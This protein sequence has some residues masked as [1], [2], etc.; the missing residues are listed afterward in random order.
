MKQGL[1]FK[2]HGRHTGNAIPVA[3]PLKQGLIFKVRGVISPH[4]QSVARCIS[5]FCQSE[6]VGVE[7]VVFIRVFYRLFWVGPL[8]ESGGILRYR[9]GFL[10]AG[11]FFVFRVG[12]LEKA[13]DFL[14]SGLFCGNGLSLPPHLPTE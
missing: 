7:G 6:K 11:T 12:R 13:L 3:I 8:A 14:P 2:R 1:I 4:F 9:V 10:Y 5:D